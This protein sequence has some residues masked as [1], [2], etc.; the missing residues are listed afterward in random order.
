M[1]AGHDNSAT[2]SHMESPVRSGSWIQGHANAFAG[3][4][5]GEVVRL[6]KET[7]AKLRGAGRRSVERLCQP[8]PLRPPVAR[9]TNPPRRHY[10]SEASP[11]TPPLT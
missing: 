4:G 3:A 11:A 6:P 1:S 7:V 10:Y 2:L 8:N 5:A 9:K